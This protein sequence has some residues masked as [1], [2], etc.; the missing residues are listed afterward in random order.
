MKELGNNSFEEVIQIIETSRSW[1][2]ASS[3]A[4]LVKYSASKQM[5]S[6]IR[7]AATC[8]QISVND[9]FKRSCSSRIRTLNEYISVF[10]LDYVTNQHAEMYS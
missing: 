2:T 7:S 1:I 8:A 5:G 10:L 3:Q 6:W 9:E 4:D